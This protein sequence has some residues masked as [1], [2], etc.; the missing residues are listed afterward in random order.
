MLQPHT[1]ERMHARLDV[2][3]ESLRLSGRLR[4]RVTGSSML[5]TI[6]PGSRV[7]IRRV[8][9]DEVQPGQIVLVRTE[10][11]FRLHRLVAIVSAPD[12]AR[13]ITRGDNHMEDDPGIDPSELLGVFAAV[14]HAPPKWRTL[15]ALLASAFRNPEQA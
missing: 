14:E 7:L 5:P 2:A 15:I 3:V 11:G 4:L 9:Q 10:T 13:L 12:G 8:A 6:R 1:T